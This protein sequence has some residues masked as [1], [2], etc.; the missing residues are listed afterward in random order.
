[1]K[2]KR[3]PLHPVALVA[4]ITAGCMGPLPPIEG[5]SSTAAPAPQPSGEAPSS[6]AAP[7]GSASPSESVD[8][9][10]A[11]RVPFHVMTLTLCS[12][13]KVTCALAEGK[14]SDAAGDGSPY[15]VAFGSAVGSIRS[16]QQ[17]LADVYRELR[18]RT[19]WGTHLAC[20]SHSLGESAPDSGVPSAA[21]APATPPARPPASNTSSDAPTGPEALASAALHVLV[22]VDNFGEV[23][24]DVNHAPG[25]CSVS[26]GESGAERCLVSAPQGKAAPSKGG[27][28]F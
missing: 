25:N 23:T 6:S 12:R 15:R 11:P 8:G 22:A 5:A 3:S 27:F 16:H 19:E 10:T 18:D 4:M 1:M 21:G 7:V 17:A 26:L 9:G 13:D 24:I 2:F 28:S 20:K 14:S